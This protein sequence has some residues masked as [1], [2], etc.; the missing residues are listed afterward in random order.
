MPITNLRKGVKTSK[1]REEKKKKIPE[2][3]NLTILT[4]PSKAFRLLGEPQKLSYLF[5]PPLKL[6]KTM[7]TPLIF[8]S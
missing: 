6:K 7:S 1:Y 8:L 2:Y 3:Q 5:D 4:Y